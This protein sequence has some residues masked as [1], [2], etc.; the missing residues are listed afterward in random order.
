MDKLSCYVVQL[1]S[2]VQLTVTPWTVACQAPLSMGFTMQEY[3][4][5]LPFPSLRHLP[6][7]GIKP[8]SLALANRF[9][10]TEP[11]VKPTNLG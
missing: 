8:T 5:G 9:Y 4:S 2:C 3:W 1:L 6:D 11:P 7:L 10:T